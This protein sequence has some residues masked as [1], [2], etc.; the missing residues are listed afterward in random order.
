MNTLVRDASGDKDGPAA[1]ASS[2][3]NQRVMLTERGRIPVR[4]QTPKGGYVRRP[5]P[6]MAF[7]QNKTRPNL[8]LMTRPIRPLSP[9]TKTQR[10]E[11]SPAEFPTTSSPPDVKA[12]SPQPI[13]EDSEDRAVV[14]TSS[15][16]MSSE[17]LNQ[18]LR[19]RGE[20]FSHRPTKVQYF[21]RSQMYAGPLE[22]KTRPH[23]RRPQ[24]PRR[25]LMHKPL[26]VR[27][28]NGDAVG[29][30]TSQQEKGSP[31]EFPEIPYNQLGEQDVPRPTQR[32]EVLIRQTGEQ[33]TADVSPLMDGLNTAVSPQS[34]KLENGERAP[35]Q[36][37][38]SGE[39]ETG[40]LV[41][42]NDSDLHNQ[43]VNTT[44]YPASTVRGRQNIPKNSSDSR[45]SRTV[46]LPKRQ[47]PSRGITGHRTQMRSSVREE[48]PKTNHAVKRVFD[49]KTGQ[50]RNAASK[51]L[52]GSDVASTGVT[53]EHLD[54]VGVTNRTSDGFTLI[55]DSP[56]GKYKNFVVTRKRDEKDETPNPKGSQRDQQRR[57]ED[58]EREDEKHQPTR[59]PGE[60]STE[61]ENR[62]SE[63][64]LAHIPMKQ[65]NTTVKPATGSEKSFKEVLPGSARSVHFE[66]LPPQTEYTV[67]LLGKGPGLLSRLHK[68]VISTG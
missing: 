56:E 63:S 21:R 64:D 43:R 12:E 10:V 22:N 19:G 7:L 9:E 4:P 36:T 59:E 61:G 15:T 51:P 68:L 28:L 11:V 16:R 27:K 41:Y 66:D 45:D 30:Q 60:R 49:T 34:N 48:D 14:R 17:Q 25:G 23:L 1:P 37:S 55:W 62:V 3:H 33:E 47:P 46:S 52:V 31:S 38:K 42:K 44:K 5:F 39:E 54:Y 32:V 65:S 26:P 67:T 35:I 24:Y 40:T 20:P 18:T 8:R 13:G 6:N 2:G 53:R 50:T 58:S 29:R 57:Q